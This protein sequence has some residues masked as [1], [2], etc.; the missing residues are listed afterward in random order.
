MAIALKS[1][2]DAYKALVAMNAAAPLGGNKMEKATAD[3]E[4]ARQKYAQLVDKVRALQRAEGDL[5]VENSRVGSSMETLKSKLNGLQADQARAITSMSRQSAHLEELK[6]RYDALPAAIARA[7]EELKALT[8]SQNASQHEIQ[9]AKNNIDILKKKHAEEG[10]ALIDKE[11]NIAR[12]TTRIAEMDIKMT[13]E[14]HKLQQVSSARGASNTELR[15]QEKNILD[16]EKAIKGEADAYTASNRKK[17]EATDRQ[18][19][20]N[21]ETV[22]ARIGLKDL[23]DSENKLGTV[24]A[25]AKQRLSEK[26]EKTKTQNA[27][28][29][30]S[31]KV[32]KEAAQAA[33]EEAA[34]LG[35][36]SSAQGRFTSAV[37]GALSVQKT[38]NAGL[39]KTG[40]ALRDFLV[41]SASSFIGN[42]L[43]T[44]VMGLQSSASTA[45]NAYKNYEMLGMSLKALSAR[46]MVAAGQFKSIDMAQDSAG[47]KSQELIKWMEQLAIKSPFSVDDISGAFRLGNALGFTS[48]QAQRLIK[49]TVDW[50]SATGGT[51]DNI[52]SVVRALGQM[53]ATGHVTLED[54]NQLTDAGL[55]ARDILRKEFA[56]EILKSKKSLE[57]LISAGVLPADRAITAMAGSMEKDFGGAADKAGDSMTG[58]LNS[59]GDLKNSALRELFTTTFQAIQVPLTKL[60]TF[61]QSDSTI[62]AIRQFG[63]M[64]GQGIG[65]MLNWIANTAV[66][67][68]I[69]AFQEFGPKVLDALAFLAAIASSAYEWGYNIGQMFQQGLADTI[70][71]LVEIISWIGDTISYWMEPHSPPKFLPEFDLWGKKTFETWI[72]G[73]KMVNIEANVMEFGRRVT[74]SLDPQTMTLKDIGQE[75]INTY[76]RGW[77]EGDF[78]LMDTI[79]GQVAGA[80]Q[81]LV[82]V[83]GMDQ[84]ALVPALVGTSEQIK[85]AIDELIQTGNVSQETFDRI[86]AVAGPAGQQIATYVQSMINSERASRALKAAQDELNQT[87]K[88]YDDRLKPLQD[89]LNALN[90]TDTAGARE[91]D[92]KRYQ[93]MVARYSE[94]G[95]DDRRNAVQKELDKLLLENQI[96]QI[97][98]EKDAAVQASTAKVDA[99]QVAADAAGQGDAVPNTIRS[100]FSKSKMQLDPGAN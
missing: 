96:D 55:G 6:A 25:A 15:A 17:A 48:S 51:G 43:S 68:A 98:K 90:N 83:G 99:A 5:G 2:E 66:P 53:N 19:R 27:E 22:S 40:S 84:S 23:I 41:G 7:E 34:A 61:L 16:L 44:L 1:H 79:K 82:D 8:V 24:L 56:P 63:K 33:K 28:Q 86:R 20:L 52:Q 69:K 4:V 77:S 73:A 85:Q 72:G 36:A 57:D 29:K 95:M 45:L 74:K 78:S 35:V 21:H 80:L 37:G 47:K 89:R 32:T 100:S 91:R 31:A 49:D 38:F 97:Q 14:Y 46:E 75:S 9:I 64:I 11:K 18:Q 26:I 10:A 76:L 60:V 50:G 65:D 87:T 3:I 58:L 59:M 12:V 93:E 39:M 42:T 70:N 54:L 81:A 30:Q 71:S 92:I 88:Q 62:S 67:Y 13:E 94:T